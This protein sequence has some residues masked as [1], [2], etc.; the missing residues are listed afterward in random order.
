MRG[1]IP[2]IVIAVVLVLGI[3]VA[4][5]LQALVP[6]S[7]APY[8]V[9]VRQDDQVVASFDLAALKAI[10]VKQVVADGKPQTGPTL[11][12]VLAK[13]GVKDYSQVEVIGPGTDDSGHLVLQQADVTPDLLLAVSNRGTVK[14]AGPAIA[15]DKW[16]RDVTEL[17]VQ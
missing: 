17:V 11:A 16:V 2:L 15:K 10:G 3:G 14:A 8:R 13:A 12:S 6:T 5:A 9:T 1:R 4:W 7:G